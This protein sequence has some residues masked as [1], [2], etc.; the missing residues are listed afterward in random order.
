MSYL[1]EDWVWL[2]Y[3]LLA[4]AAVAACSALEEEEELMPEES[5]EGGSPY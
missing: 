3:Q 4:E 2:V 1:E 5:R